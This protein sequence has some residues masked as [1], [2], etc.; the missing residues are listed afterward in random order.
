[1]NTT[2]FLVQQLP[3]LVPYALV[4]LV[5]LV[6]SLVHLQ[7]CAKPALLA[8]IGCGA[9]L[10]ITLLTPLFQALAFSHGDSYGWARVGMLHS[11]VSLVSA[12]VHVVG[13]SL[14][15]AAIFIDRRQ[16]LAKRDEVSRVATHATLP[17]SPFGSTPSLPSADR[18]PTQEP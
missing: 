7:R 15:I 1:M 11:I 13:F 5:G 12:L 16:P 8:A 9:L 2:S 14:L 6:V 17:T 10:C 3:F 4:F 18:L